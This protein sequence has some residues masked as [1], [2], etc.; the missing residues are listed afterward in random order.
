MK[1]WKSLVI[2]TFKGQ[3]KFPNL[4]TRGQKTAPKNQS[5]FH[6]LVALVSN[7][8][9]MMILTLLIHEVLPN[10]R[11]LSKTHFMSRFLSNY[12]N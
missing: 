5:N 11:C 1:T 4:F 3:V 12:K 9:S 6:Q 7:N 8:L 2:K 10:V